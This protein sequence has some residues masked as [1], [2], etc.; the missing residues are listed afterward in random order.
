[1]DLASLILPGLFATLFTSVGGLVVWYFQS[2][3]EKLRKLKDG[4]QLQ[5]ATLKAM[6]PFIRMFAGLGNAKAQAHALASF[7]GYPYRKTV[8][9][10]TM[11]GSDEVVRAYNAMFQHIY[12]SET[13]GQYPRELMRRW[14]SVLLAIRKGG[15]NPDT[16]LDEW[17]MLT[18]TIKDIETLR[19]P[20]A[21]STG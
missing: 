5:P 10:L 2:R 17:D 20:P 1:M 15:G 6:D 7:R 13:A 12:K 16:T 8:F 9:D 4:V 14:A 11:F 18:A 21:A 19:N 3:A